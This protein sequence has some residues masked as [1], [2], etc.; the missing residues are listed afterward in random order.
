MSAI[1]AYHHDFIERKSR[2]YNVIELG[3]MELPQLTEIACN[4]NITVRE[5]SGKQTII[6]AILNNQ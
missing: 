4:M 5:A 2:L 3:K 6:Y 1:K